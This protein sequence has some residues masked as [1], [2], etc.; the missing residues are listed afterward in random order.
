MR[1][2]SD[3]SSCLQ[4]GPCRLGLWRRCEQSWSQ[5]T[6]MIS[7]DLRKLMR[8]C[9]CGQ[10]IAIVHRYEMVDMRA[11]SLTTERRSGWHDCLCRI[12]WWTAGGGRWPWPLLPQQPGGRPRTQENKSYQAQ[13]QHL[14]SCLATASQCRLV[15]T[16]SL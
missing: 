11:A 9:P 16:C 6:M 8:S 15:D 10:N 7:L 4:L 2:T 1:H 5:C 12:L 3:T 14:G 13:V